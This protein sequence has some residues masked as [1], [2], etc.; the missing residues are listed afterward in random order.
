MWNYNHSCW[1]CTFD[2]KYF[3]LSALLSVR[4]L[5][6]SS[7]I[8]A[9]GDKSSVIFDDLSWWSVVS[10]KERS[11][12]IVLP[13]SMHLLYVVACTSYMTTYNVKQCNLRT[14]S[15]NAVFPEA[16]S[17]H[18]QAVNQLRVRHDNVGEQNV[19]WICQKFHRALT[20]RPDVVISTAWYPSDNYM[21]RHHLLFPEST[22]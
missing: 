21:W 22:V 1:Q 14:K 13:S 18:T 10:W 7:K 12:V 5:Y 16:P 6:I 8:T 20:I 19:C 9:H 2:G 15:W 4:K 17:L 3:I 11:N